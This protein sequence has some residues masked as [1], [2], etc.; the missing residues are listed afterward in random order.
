MAAVWRTW[1]RHDF[2]RLRH[3]LHSEGSYFFVSEGR[4]VEGADAMVEALKRAY[5]DT[6][7]EL[8]DPVLTE[9]RDDVVLASA[10]LRRSEPGGGHS[11]RHAIWLCLVRNGQFV[12]SST[13]PNEQAAHEAFAEGWPE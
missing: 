11:A 6:A 9:L 2:E 4:T 10:Y 8:G 13:F 3:L 7:Y 1:Q 5:A 12:R